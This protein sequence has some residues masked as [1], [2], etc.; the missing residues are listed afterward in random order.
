MMGVQVVLQKMDAIVNVRLILIGIVTIQILHLF[1]QNVRMEKELTLQP[2]LKN[3]MNGSFQEEFLLIRQVMEKD[4][5][6]TVLVLIPVGN[7]K[8][9]ISELQI[10][11]QKFV[12]TESLLVMKI[13]ILDLFNKTGN[14]NQDV[15]QVLLLVGI[16][17]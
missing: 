7:V 3:V 16:V 10:L 5:G 2:Q 14:V 8:E 6:I 13:V 17:Q 12:R 11:V 4:V 9:E 15:S 1:A